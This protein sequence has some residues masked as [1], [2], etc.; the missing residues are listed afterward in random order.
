MVSSLITSVRGSLEDSGANWVDVAV[1]GVT[2]RVSV[3]AQSIETLGQHGSQVR[4]FTTLIVREDNLSLYGFDT[5][6]AR[7]TFET[8]IGISGVGPRVALSILSTFTPPTL[9]ALVESA[10]VKSI[11]TVPGVGRRTASRIV[12]EL[13]GKLDHLD[14]A[15]DASAASPPD[16]DAIDALTALG[17]TQAEARDALA[18]LTDAADL[19]V[20]DRVRLALQHLAGA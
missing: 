18:A 15:A 5:P 17:Y 8:L 6:D 4:L 14:W 20:E 9:A 12:L 7:L 10:D 11:T 3:P 1:G 13:K 19:T 2:L 16:D